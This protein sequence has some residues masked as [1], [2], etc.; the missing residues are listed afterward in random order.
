MKHA[1]ISLN[2]KDFE[3]SMRSV[4]EEEILQK[5]IKSPYVPF[6]EAIIKKAR[7]TPMGKSIEV[8]VKDPKKAHG[9]SMAIRGY[10]KR[11]GIGDE[12]TSGNYRT[13]VYCGKRNSAFSAKAGKNGL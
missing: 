2:L 7:A 5:K 1:E 12:F 4:T 11:T 9:L 6:I 3:A 13:F 10:L 8:D